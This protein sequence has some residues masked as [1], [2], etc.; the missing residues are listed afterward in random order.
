MSTGSGR[1]L[2]VFLGLFNEFV[3]VLRLFYDLVF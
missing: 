2:F 1:V 3:T